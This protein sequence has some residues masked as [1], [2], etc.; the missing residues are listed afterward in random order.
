MTPQKKK[1]RQSGIELLRIVAM[2]LVMFGHTHCQTNFY[3]PQAADIL[4]HPFHS[5][6]QLL[7]SCITTTGVG[8]FIAISGWFGI[9]FSI[10]G[11]S[12]YL[13]Q[14]AFILLA[15]YVFSIIFLAVPID[16]LGIKYC[17]GLYEGYWFVLGYLGLYMASPILNSF[18]EHASK[19]EYQ[20]FLIAFYL[21]Q[22]IYS[23]VTG[24]YS[25]Y[26]GYS[27]ILFCGIYLTAAYLK[28]YPISWMQ[29]HAIY[30]LVATILLMA[31][32]AFISTWMVNNAGRQIRDDNPLVI[33]TCI[34]FVISFSKLKFQSQFVNWLA[35][36]C[37]A[38]YL[39]HF[40]P[41]I[42]P[43]LMTTTSSIYW[44]YDGLIYVAL[45]FAELLMVYITCTLFDQLRILSWELIN[46]I[47]AKNEKSIH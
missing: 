24:W 3:L 32:I 38:V 42:H 39:I 28:K 45:L 36:S 27:I 8:I 4:S 40:S 12:K 1:I 31:S 7:Y 14:V 34:L 17:L 44:Q 26:N 16:V 25:Y 30:L 46:K 20:V 9:K 6:F 29:R 37:F 21:F 15:I 35:A 13:F 47:L 5:F 43:Y 22:C 2:M 19:K 23:W 10:K 41:F 33:L 11:L 18:I